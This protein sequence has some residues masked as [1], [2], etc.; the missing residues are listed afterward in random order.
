MERRIHLY[1]VMLSCLQSIKGISV[2][3]SPPIGPSPLVT[4]SSDVNIRTPM[5]HIVNEARVSTQPTPTA[6][7][8][9]LV[10]PVNAPPVAN[11]Q[12]S[13]NQNGIHENWPIA[14][15]H[16]QPPLGPSPL[17]TH[18]SDGNIHTPSPHVV[19]EAGM[20]TQSPPMTSPIHPVHTP[21]LASTNAVDAQRSPSA[22]Q[23]T[24]SSP[25]STVKDASKRESTPYLALVVAMHILK[26]GLLDSQ[27]QNLMRSNVFPPKASEDFLK[28]RTDD[29]KTRPNQGDARESDGS[30]SDKDPKD[31][32]KSDKPDD[33]S[34]RNTT[35]VDVIDDID[36]I[37]DEDSEERF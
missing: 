5:P 20:S 13:F 10:N 29:A 9:H 26:N 27:P 36:D 7:P 15:L 31:D 1:L 6:S 37:D 17:V 16:Q 33:Q 11:A 8:I 28:K 4:H 24:Q 21:S 12:F 2:N 3:L 32:A 14:N 34:R 23:K 25:S 19:N 18:S 35:T 22:S 30:K